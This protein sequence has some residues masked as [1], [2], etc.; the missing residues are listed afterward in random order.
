MLETSNF[1]HYLA[2]WSISDAMHDY[3]LIGR[4]QGHV[5]YYNFT[6]LKYLCIGYSYR[7]QILYTSW[8]REVLAFWWLTAP[9]QVGVVRV[10]WPISTFWGPCH[11]F[12]TDEAKYLKFGLQIERKEYWQHTC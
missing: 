6:P 9:P 2:A 8:P 5:T 3:P 4:G 12:G 7:V 1:V 11:I 10:A